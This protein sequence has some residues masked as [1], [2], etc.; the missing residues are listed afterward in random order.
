M[1]IR[2]RVTIQVHTDQAP[3]KLHSPDSKVLYLIKKYFIASLLKGPRASMTFWGMEKCCI[4]EVPPQ[5]GT[6]T[7]KRC[8]ERGSDGFVGVDWISH[9]MVMMVWSSACSVRSLSI[10]MNE[11]R[12]KL[13]SFLFTLLLKN[14][15]NECARS[16]GVVGD[17]RGWVG[18]SAACC[19]GRR[20]DISV[21][22]TTN[23]SILIVCHLKITKSKGRA[24]SIFWNWNHIKARAGFKLF[25]TKY[26][27]EIAAI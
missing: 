27:D 1:M 15:C 26:D 2:S 4:N 20:G 18:G 14:V 11:G 7:K 12:S 22:K 21:G 8:D 25:N 13:A 3:A 5:R 10:Q 16:D 6:W 24:Y 9:G 17:W 19:V 23:L